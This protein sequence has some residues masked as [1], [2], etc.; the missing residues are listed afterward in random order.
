MSNT[1]YKPTKQFIKD[2]YWNIWDIVTEEEVYE[3]AV[4]TGLGGETQTSFKPGHIPWNKGKKCDYVSKARKEYWN[5]WR[6]SNP[7]YKD[8]WKKYVKKNPEDI[9]KA[10]NTTPLNK[11]II[12][13]PHCDKK[14]NVGNMKRWHFDKCKKRLPLEN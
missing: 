10:D 9:I 2:T 4:L 8:K 7:G 6:E 12:Q 1:I 11:T 13:C 3:G 14:G 5:Q